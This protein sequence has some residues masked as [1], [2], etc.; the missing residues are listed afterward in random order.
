VNEIFT[1]LSVF[2]P[3]KVN[4]HLAVLDKRS[5]GFHNLESFFLALDFGDKLNFTGAKEENIM[6]I[7]SIS[8]QDAGENGEWAELICNPTRNIIFKA[9][10]LFR[11]KTGF[12]HGLKIAV[13]KRIPLG[14]GLGGGSSDAAAALLALNKMAG[15]PLNREALLETAASLGSDVPFFIH[16]TPA[17]RVTGRGENIEPIDIPPLF[18]V[19]VNPGFPSDT[20]RAFSL[21]NE[22]R[23]SKD[24]YREPQNLTAL[25]WSKFKNDFL[26][27]FPEKERDVYNEIISAL[28]SLGALY[29]SLSGAGATCF[30][31]FKEEKQAQKASE[32]LQNK[33]DLVVTACSLG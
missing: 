21:L 17:A 13:E 14:G 1:E 8:R 15:S 32:S 3:A 12:S 29:A 28:R 23:S 5:D 6:E 9:V 30:G 20:A 11:Q 25:E 4:L 27:V 31:V 2:A 16:E 7:S 26:E 22:Y 10:T 24:F 18:L 19:L 33:W